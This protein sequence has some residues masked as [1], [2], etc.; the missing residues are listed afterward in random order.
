MT[1]HATYRGIPLEEID[2]DQQS[3]SLLAIGYSETAGSVLKVW[4]RPIDLES[5]HW[6]GVNAAFLKGRVAKQFLERR[7]R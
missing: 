6:I 5:G 2:L 1:H 7:K 3:E 4:L